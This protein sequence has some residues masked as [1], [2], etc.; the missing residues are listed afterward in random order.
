MNNTGINF[1]GNLYLK[2]STKWTEGMKRAINS[3]NS[4]QKK[5]VNHDV[6]GKISVKTE[7]HNV[8]YS[9]LHKKG[10]NIYKISLITKQ[11]TDSLIGKLKNLLGINST[12]NIVCGNYHSEKTSIDRLLNIIIE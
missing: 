9:C 10:D 11:E 5:L 4:I 12:K 7:K 1:T 6:I 3:N 8:P 2:N